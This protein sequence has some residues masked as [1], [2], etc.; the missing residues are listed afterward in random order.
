[1][2]SLI[3]SLGLLTP[4]FL[5]TPTAARVDPLPRSTPEVA[6]PV[7]SLDAA[8]GDDGSMFGQ[9]LT[10]DG[11]RITDRDIKLFLIYGPCAHMLELAKLNLIAEDQV[12][13]NAVEAAEKAI[14]QPATDAA[15]AAVAQREAPARAAAEAA[16]KEREAATPFDSPAARQQALDEELKQEL[17]KIWPNP[18]ARQQ[19]YDEI[20]KREYDKL[21]AS[22]EAQ[23]KALDAEITKQKSL[24]REKYTV[25][26]ADVQKEFDATV[27]DFKQK[28]PVLDLPAEIS[29]AYRTVDWYRQDLRTMMFF[30][31]VFLPPNPEEWPVVTREAVRADSGEVLVDDAKLSY[32]ARKAAAE[33]TGGPLPKEDVIYTNMMR[34]I[35]RDAVFGL[36][37]FKTAGDGIAPDLCLWADTN[38]DGKP[39]LSITIDEMWK[40][41]SDTVSETEI[42]E[43]KQWFVTY[44]ATEDRLKEDG[45]LL[46]P[47]DC[48][49]ALA[50]LLAQFGGSV[51]SIDQMATKTY[52]FP[53]LETY[54][55]YY[56]LMEGFKKKVEPLLRPGPAN[57][58]PQVLREHFDRANRVMGLG[59]V[60]VEVMLISAF[61]I[62]HFAWK[63]D[64]WTKAEQ[65]AKEIKAKIEE[66]T[67]E[68]NEQ[69]AKK[70]EAKAK[71]E[72][73]KPEKE[74]V[75]PY[76]FWSQM[77]D[78]HSDYWDPPAPEGANGKG[79]DVGYKRKG[80]FGPRYRND[81]INYV[82]ESYY[83][84]WATG[85]LITDYVFFDQT[86]GSVAGP[87][88]GP[89]GYYLT[90]VLRRSPPTRPLNL[91][92]PKHVDLLR[93]DYLRFAFVQYSKE[94]VAKAKVTGF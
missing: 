15:V 94:A 16:I 67:K 79:S 11:K 39:E 57:D 53:S 24:L 65:L 34:Q 26:D 28:Y 44:T 82:G 69:L 36:V 71:G 25:S 81:L 89:L 4:T 30:D 12:W 47:Q 2:N 50:S 87:F 6:S 64:G 23:K 18:S 72:E 27:A 88:K 59:Q 75:E 42:N 62:P 29:R 49:S 58:L 9:P 20:F 14:K 8:Q 33:K 5:P 73:Y 51:T 80:R 78:D 31:R 35:V 52:Y 38:G 63:K 74:A 91:A 13:R 85:N 19:L 86:E 10:I 84:N 56:C 66:N 3:L 41:V 17:A 1:M 46:S 60:E 55:Q 90:R 54:K 22:P 43:A 7:A 48:S 21:F 32:E 76:R 83:S 45:F 40:K 77:M 92:E 68:Y 70:N 37:D 61:D 93:D